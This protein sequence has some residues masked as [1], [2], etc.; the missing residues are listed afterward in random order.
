MNKKKFF[1]ML[2]VS[3][4]MLGWV[5]QIEASYTCD[6]FGKYSSSSVTNTFAFP[7]SSYRAGSQYSHASDYLY[8][9]NSS[10]QGSKMS[11]NN[12]ISRWK[13][14]G[15]YG[16]EFL[17]GEIVNTLWLLQGYESA[18]KSHLETPLPFIIYT[19][20]M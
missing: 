17:S 14:A 13:K 18:Y 6:V 4:G 12:N 5:F 11:G 1:I 19:S 7:V 20:F 10:L 9:S 16:I 8:F 2:V 15:I 3:I